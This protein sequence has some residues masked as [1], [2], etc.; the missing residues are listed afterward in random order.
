M[1]IYVIQHFSYLI[2]EIFNLC[3]LM[4]TSIGEKSKVYLNKIECMKS[5]FQKK[6][7][8]RVGSGFSF[9]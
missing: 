4:I 3:S 8:L 2:L 6:K 5:E 1:Y 7:P 9:F